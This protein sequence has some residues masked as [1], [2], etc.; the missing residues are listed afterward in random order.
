M[1]M[2]T[3]RDFWKTRRDRDEPV[4]TIIV[5]AGVRLCVVIYDLWAKDTH[6]MWIV[7]EPFTSTRQI[8]L[9]IPEIIIAKREDVAVNIKEVVENVYRLHAQNA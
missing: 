8:V 5:V 7:T 4:S 1:E 3:L 2:M 6:E 9:R